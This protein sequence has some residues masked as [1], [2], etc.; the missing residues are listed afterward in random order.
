MRLE[1][2]NVNNKFYKIST[3]ESIILNNGDLERRYIM[4]L[5]IIIKSCL[6]NI[7][8]QTSR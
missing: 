1:L 5:L 7:G 3:D 8:L 2:R 4:I 6:K